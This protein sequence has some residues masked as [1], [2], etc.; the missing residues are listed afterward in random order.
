MRRWILG[1]VAVGVA[2]ALW[3]WPAARTEQPVALKGEAPEFRGID[4]WLN[5]KPLRMK[6]LRGRVVVLHFWAFG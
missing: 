4:E 1:G 5:T 6:D 3:S 2:A